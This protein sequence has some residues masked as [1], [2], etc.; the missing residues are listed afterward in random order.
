[1]GI[2]KIEITKAGKRQM[3]VDTDALPAE[4]YAAALSAGLKVMLNAKM[5]KITTAKLE[6]DDLAKA[7]ADA[8]E[9]AEVNL[10]SILAGEYKSG[11]GAT[12]TT[13]ADGKK[14]PQVVMTEALRIAKNM[15]KDQLKKAN[16]RVSHVEPKQITE[17]AKEFIAADP[18]ILAAAQ[19]AVAKRMAAPAPVDIASMIAPSPKLVAAA[20]ER[21]AE[22]KTQLSAK[23]A[24]KVAPRKA[25]Q[26]GSAATH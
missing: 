10:A 11:R 26:Q 14:V 1:M 21:K 17:A 12:A 7:Q 3:E 25:T 15:V 8:W 24:G 6:G 2:L 13:D 16:I 22:R 23:Q 5:S 9:K 20:E 18:S 19:E 4:M